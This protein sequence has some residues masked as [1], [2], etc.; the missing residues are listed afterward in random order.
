M[1]S[2]IGMNVSDSNLS[3]TTAV[4]HEVSDVAPT[5]TFTQNDVNDIVKRAKNEAVE[6]D[7][8]LRVEQ[9]EYAQRKYEDANQ[10]QQTSSANSAS[11]TAHVAQ[12]SDEKIRQIVAEE[13][14]RQREAMEKENL[15]QSQKAYAEQIV[16]KFVSKV[17]SGKAAYQDF[18]DVTGDIEFGRFPNTVQLLA[19][20]V[21]N[22]ADVLYELGKNR[23]KLADIENLS[24]YSAKDAIK[25]VQR[26]A[27]SIKA[28]KNAA[29][30]RLPNEPLSQMRP[31]TNGTDNGGVRSVSDY[32]RMF[33]V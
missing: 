24:Q 6:R 9:P 1:D 31:S 7:R 29:N 11:N 32:K 20:N 13:T 18:N 8:R 25:E 12:N 26:L 27:S 5:K 2:S 22:V 21:D 17:E 10:G 4:S 33:R 28:N 15:S 30:I 14:K 16:Q 3:G 19:E 23:F